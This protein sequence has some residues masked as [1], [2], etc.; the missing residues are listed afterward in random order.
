MGQGR[1]P[2]HQDGMPR[3]RGR[4]IAGVNYGAGTQF[5]RGRASE[6]KLPLGSVTV[7]TV[8][9]KK[10]AWV[11]IAEPNVWRLR[12]VVEWEKVHGPVPAGKLIHHRDHDSLNDAPGNLVALTRKEHAAEHQRELVLAAAARLGLRLCDCKEGA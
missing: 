2:V 1:A 4:F 7:R 9:G 8:R 6:N 3:H 5:Q 12:A 11:K 10:R